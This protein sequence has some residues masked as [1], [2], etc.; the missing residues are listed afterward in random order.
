MTRV[1]LASPCSMYDITGQCISGLN[2]ARVLSVL[3]SYVPCGLQPTQ[4]ELVSQA[5]IQFRSVRLPS[6]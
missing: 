4:Q 1:L 5:C 2:F 6:F 3:F